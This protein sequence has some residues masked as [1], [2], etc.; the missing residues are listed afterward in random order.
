MKVISVVSDIWCPSFIRQKQ[1]FNINSKIYRKHGT[2]SPRKFGRSGPMIQKSCPRIGIPVP[3]RTKHAAGHRCWMKNGVCVICH[4]ELRFG[5]HRTGSRKFYSTLMKDLIDDYNAR[6][7]CH[8]SWI[9][10]VWSVNWWT[11]LQIPHDVAFHRRSQSKVVSGV[12][13]RKYRYQLFKATVW[14]DTK[15]IHNFGQ[16][17]F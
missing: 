2:V 3:S 4:M 13:G 9:L 11:S 12:S 16:N 14:H 10:R 8:V 17:N 6:R 5:L 15:R 7:P 1:A